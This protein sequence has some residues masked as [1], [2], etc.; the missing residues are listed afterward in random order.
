ML[1]MWGENT[2]SSPAPQIPIHLSFEVHSQSST[3]LGLQIH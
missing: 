2:I 3:N 1:I